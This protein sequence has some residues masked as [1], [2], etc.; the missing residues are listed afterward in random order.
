MNYK[1]E[2]L[3]YILNDSCVIQ[4]EL[5]FIVEC[6]VLNEP[7]MSSGLVTFVNL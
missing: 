7:V 6:L 5:E 4:L 1:W 2:V 3:E